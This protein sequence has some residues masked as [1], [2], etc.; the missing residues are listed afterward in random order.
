MKM[1]QIELSE[2]NI[3][4]MNPFAFRPTFLKYRR[5]HMHAALWL[6]SFLSLALPRSSC[7]N[8]I[9]GVYS[10]ATP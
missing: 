7:K 10:D 5:L 6:T 4:E 1:S 9:S 3:S 8:I 2:V